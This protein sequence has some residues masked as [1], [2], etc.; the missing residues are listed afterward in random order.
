MSEGP[1]L[2]DLLVAAPR[3]SHGQAA[4]KVAADLLA[5]LAPLDGAGDLATRLARPSPV[6]DLLA[7]LADHSPYLWHLARSDPQRLVAILRRNPAETLVRLKDSLAAAVAVA[8]AS[9]GDAELMRGLRR[10]KQELALL[11]ALADLGGAWTVEQVTEALSDHADASVSASLR[12]LLLRALAAGKLEGLDAADPERGCGLV[13]L[14][15]GKHGARELNYSSDID[16]IVFYDPE[17]APLAPGVEAAPFFVRIVRDLVRLLQER[18]PDGYVFRTDLRLRPDPAST[19][20]AIALAS[21]FAYY[22]TVGQNW[23][24]AALIKARPVAGDLAIG[25]AFLRDL[26]P[27]IWQV[28]RLRRHRRH[29]RDEEADPRGPRA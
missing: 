20:T 14:A 18:T 29:P 27:F 11:V 10:A 28:L 9:Q 22:E 23:E 7:A 12:F 19:P 8:T 2:I 25:E 1:P 13:I 6:P 4:R 26:A 3:L 17:R 24:R 21:A 16:V 15:L 5:D